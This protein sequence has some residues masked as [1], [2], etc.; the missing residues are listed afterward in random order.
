M[1]RKTA[2]VLTTLLLFVAG[3]IGLKSFIENP[4]PVTHVTAAPHA[5]PTASPTP[6]RTYNNRIVEDHPDPTSVGTD[7]IVDG[8][9]YVPCV[10]E[11]YDGPQACFW[12]AETRGNGGGSSFL[13]NGSRV[14]PSTP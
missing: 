6:T 3:W 10:T 9:R 14:L 11:D 13:W 1:T 5:A 2:L 7:I 8:T 12:D 4:N